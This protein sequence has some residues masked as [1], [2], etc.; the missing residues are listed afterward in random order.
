MDKIDRSPLLIL[1]IFM[2]AKRFLQSLLLVCQSS[3]PFDIGKLAP[4]C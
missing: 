4:D 3:L 2:N 1:A